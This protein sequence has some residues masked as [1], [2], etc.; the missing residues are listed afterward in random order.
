MLAPDDPV[1]RVVVRGVRA[2]ARLPQALRDYMM[3]GSY[4]VAHAKVPKHDIVVLSDVFLSQKYRDACGQ[5]GSDP[6]SAEL[7]WLEWTLYQARRAGRTVSLAMHIPAGVDCYS[8]SRPNACPPEG[9]AF[10]TGA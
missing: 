9:E 5:T 4:A 6:G 3:G 8:S 7:A 1:L 2:I 10:T